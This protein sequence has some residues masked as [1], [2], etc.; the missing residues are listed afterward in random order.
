M[1]LV[2]WAHGVGSCIDTVDRLLGLPHSYEVSLVAGLGY[3]ERKVQGHN[4]R[5]PSSTIAARNTFDG[6]LGL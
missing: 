1:Q 5:E 4:D 6:E 3:P 2:A